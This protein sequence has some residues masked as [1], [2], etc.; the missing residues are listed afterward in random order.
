MSKVISMFYELRD[1]NTQEILESNVGQKEI[2]FLTNKGHVIKAIEDAVLELTAG[3]EKKIT[4]KAA[5]AAGEYDPN[6]IQELPKEQFAGLDLEVN[7]ELFGEGEDGSSVR[8]VVKEIGESTVIVDF[9]HP[10]A[11]KDLEFNVKITENRD[12]TEDELLTGVVAGQE[13]CGCG[14]GDECCGGG[15]EHKH[16]HECCGGHDHKD[17]ECCTD[18]GHEH[19]DGECCTSG[20]HEHKD[21]E[22][23]TGDAHK[24][25]DGQCCGGHH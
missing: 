25:K 21:G 5:D 20:S 12:A 15:H 8:V 10:Y 14:N 7:M 18:G 23:C 4:I 2:S 6:A 11:G 13:V 19:K 3:D 16:E 1:A 22:C 17:G 24:H 9:N